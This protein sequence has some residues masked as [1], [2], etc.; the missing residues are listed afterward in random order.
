ME[1]DLE[2][3]RAAV[4][5]APE[6]SGARA[7]GEVLLMIAEE[8]GQAAAILAADLDNREMGLDRCFEALRAYARGHQKDGF[9]GCMCRRFEQD[10]PVIRVVCDFYK[11]PAEA[12]AGRAEYTDSQA[13][14]HTDPQAHGHEDG[15]VDLLDLL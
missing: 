10:N 15:P 7:I 8:S 14:G 13:H 9:W 1:K 11:I 2:R 6:G 12:F 5:A 3:I 4:Q